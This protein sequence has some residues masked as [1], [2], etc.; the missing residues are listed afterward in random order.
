[1]ANKSNV[2]SSDQRTLWNMWNN[3]IIKRIESPENYRNINYLR[4]QRISISDSD[5]ES[6]RPPT[7]GFSSCFIPKDTK[8]YS[9]DSF[10][11]CAPSRDHLGSKKILKVSSSGYLQS[12]DKTPE[13]I[14]MRNLNLSNDTHCN[15]ALLEMTSG[16]QLRVRMVKNVAPNEEIL[17]W[18]SEEILALM[19]IPFL[20]PANIRG[21]K[22][23]NKSDGL[24]YFLE[25]FLIIFY[26]LIFQVKTVIHATYAKNPTKVPI[27]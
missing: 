26:L 22:F 18:F 13:S 3:E 6:D 4:H 15:N 17:L 24:V 7:G 8:S 10:E 16:K 11:I 5:C 25:H 19:Q 21:G 20:T 27:R 2:D 9:V 12:E 1:M 23:M 14:W